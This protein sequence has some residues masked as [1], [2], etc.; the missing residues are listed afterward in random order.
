MISKITGWTWA[1]LKEM[2]ASDLAYW[3]SKAIDFQERLNEAVKV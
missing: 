3:Y 1:D 2:D